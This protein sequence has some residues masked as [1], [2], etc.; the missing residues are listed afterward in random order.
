[1]L[2]IDPH[3]ED[4]RY[5]RDF[6]E[7]YR[8]KWTTY[9]AGWH[10]DLTPAINPPA[11]SILRAERVPDFGGDTHW[12]NLV[13]AYQSLSTPLRALADRLQAEH[14]FF[15]GCQ[16]QPADPE[17]IAICARARAD[18]QVSIHPV[19]RVHPETGEHAL[20]VHPASVSRIVGLTP[21]ESR[22]LLNVFFAQIIR[23]EYTVRFRWQAGSVAI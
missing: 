22:R 14:T 16:L 13:A 17:D 15:A 5:G 19:V 1:M 11:I 7:R 18:A 9:T 20:Y 2:T 8:Q 10:T 6:E 3:A 12:T 23:P 4:E 21:A